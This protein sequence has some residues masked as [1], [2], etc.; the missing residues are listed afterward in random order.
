MALARF[1]CHGELGVCAYNG[2]QGRPQRGP[3]AELPVGRAGNI[4][5]NLNVLAI[6]IYLQSKKYI[7]RVAIQIS[8][9]TTEAVLD[10]RFEHFIVIILPSDKSLQYIK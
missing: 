4:P 3:T 8:L 5:Q 6:K 1:G 2:G 9:E 7:Y 10:F